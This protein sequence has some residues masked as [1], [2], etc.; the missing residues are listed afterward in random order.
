MNLNLSNLLHMV[1]NGG[2]INGQGTMPNGKSARNQ[3]GR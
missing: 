3:K 2:A 1:G